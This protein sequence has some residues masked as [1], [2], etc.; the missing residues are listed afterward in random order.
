MSFLPE[1]K[2]EIYSLRAEVVE[3]CEQCGGSGYQSEGVGEV[4]RCDCMLIFRYLKELV[5]ARIPKDYWTLTLKDLQVDND[6]KK[7]VRVYVKN[8]ERAKA[9]GLGMVLSG[10]NG[11][12]KTSM[13]CELAKM[14]IVHGY[15]VSYFTLS[16]YIT[17]LYQKDQERLNAFEDADFLLIDELDKQADG[18]NLVKTVDEFLR[19]MFN[20][21]KSLILGT[22]WSEAE[23]GEQLG[24]STVSLLRR[25]CNFLTMDGEDYSDVLQDNYFERLTTSFD[26][27]DEN[28]WKLANRM[29]QLNG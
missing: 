10:K 16:S 3:G 14:A 1:V 25:R 13:M 21:G 15:S 18:K 27:Y 20:S 8:M 5:K 4:S 12:G 7:F 19:R 22:N 9:N 2:A 28:I 17:A 24:E 29:E 11:I 23:L 6:Y 26:F